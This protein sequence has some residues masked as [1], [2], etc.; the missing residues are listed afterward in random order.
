MKRK[1]RKSLPWRRFGYAILIIIKFGELLLWFSPRIIKCFEKLYQTQGGVF[2]Q[3][4][5]HLKVGKKNSACAPFFNPLLS[6]Y[7]MKHSSLCLIYYLKTQQIQV[8]EAR[9]K[10][11]FHLFSNC[12]C[13][14]SESN[15]MCHMEHNKTINLSQPCNKLFCKSACVIVKFTSY[16]DTLERTTWRKRIEQ[17]SIYVEIASTYESNRM[18]ERGLGADISL[19]HCLAT[20]IWNLAHKSDH[21]AEI[22]GKIVW[23][24]A[25]APRPEVL[26]SWYFVCACTVSLWLNFLP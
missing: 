15:C 2:H 22:S 25:L 13:V 9:D 16:H 1:Q 12:A 23:Y 17:C 7:L 26:L 10:R 20:G 5:K 6:G 4:S 8:S 18:D 3:I 21:R 19:P 14:N 11:L 24:D